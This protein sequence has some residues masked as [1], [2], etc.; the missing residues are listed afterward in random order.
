MSGHINNEATQRDEYFNYLKET[1]KEVNPILLS[2]F[3]QLK[4]QDKE[5]YKLFKPI[6][7]KR[8]KFPQLRPVIMRISYEL[9]GGKNWQRIAPICAVMEL[10]NMYLYL[11]NWIFDNKKSLWSGEIKEVRGKVNNTIISASIIRE[12]LLQTIKKAKIS[13][14][15]KDLIEKEIAES[16]IE[17]YYSQYLDINLTIDRFKEFKSDEQFIKLYEQKSKLQSGSFYK[18]S[19]KTG[20][21][22]GKGSATQIK[23]ISKICELFGTGLHISNDLGDFAPP[24]SSKATFGK[25]YQ[26]QL[27][28]IKENRLT[29]PIYYLLKYGNQKEQKAL[30]KLVGNYKPTSKQILEAG[31]SIH[32][33]GAYVFCKKYIRKFFT[34][35]KRELHKSFEKSK[36][37][38]L[39]ALML[40][41]I[42]T[43]KFLA[44]LRKLQ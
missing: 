32:S 27:A 10:H 18:L 26:D 4:K 40:S 31:K 8:L 39:Y 21:M 17:T 11:H 20:A 12:L 22:L 37:R 9:V 34:S 14:A 24:K 25:A 43:N 19:G 42:R 44:E 41:A 15:S 13:L 3:E 5:F 29:L 1:A 6:L 33:S 7:D 2:C 28:D 16:T 35:A 36:K 23:A 38:D 30:L